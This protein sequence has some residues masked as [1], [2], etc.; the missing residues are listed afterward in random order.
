LAIESLRESMS[1]LQVFPLVDQDAFSGSH[2]Q[3]SI[4]PTGKQ[5]TE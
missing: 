1:L 5:P 4:A 3:V 2:Y